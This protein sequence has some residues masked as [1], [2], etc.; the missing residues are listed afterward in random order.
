VHE[1]HPALEVVATG[2]HDRVEVVALAKRSQR[3]R[4]LEREPREVRASR[5]PPATRSTQS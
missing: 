3:R 1:Q 5:S 2:G 4:V